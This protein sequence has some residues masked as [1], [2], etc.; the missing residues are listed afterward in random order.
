MSLHDNARHR[1]ELG[2]VDHKHLSDGSIVQT[3]IPDISAVVDEVIGC[4]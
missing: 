4:V 3:S 2:F 1:P